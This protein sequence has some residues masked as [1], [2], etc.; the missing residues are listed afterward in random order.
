MRSWL[1]MGDGWQSDRTVVRVDFES[2]GEQVDYLEGRL[3]G[4]E[5]G[6]SNSAR[7]LGVVLMALVSFVGPG[8]A[9]AGG[10]T[11][12]DE[13][14]SLF[15]VHEVALSGGDD[16][17]NPFDKDCQVTFVPPSGQ[18]VTVDCF[19]DGDGTW[20]ARVYVRKV[21]VWNW[22]SESQDD[23]SLDGQSGNFQAETS[24]L[25]GMLK[26]HRSNPHVWMTD[27][28]TT[29]LHISDTAYR[30]FK[31]ASVSDAYQQYVDEDAALGITG[32][33]CMLLG[34]ANWD[35]Y[36]AGG[37]DGSK[38]RV[39]IAS[40]Q[41]SEDRLKWMLENHPEVYVQLILFPDG[42]MGDDTW[43]NGHS[44][45]QREKM[46]RYIIARFAAFPNMFWEVMNDTMV[47]SQQQ[48]P[49][50]W[51]AATDVGSYFR[52][53]DPFGH[54]IAFGH[55]RDYEYPFAG[56]DWSTYIIGYTA[57][58]IACDLVDWYGY[59]QYEKH[60]YNTEDYY[61]TYHPPAH[62]R[63]F[64]RRFVWSYLLSGA[65]ATY[66]GLWDDIIPYSSSGMTGL[67]DIIHIRDFFRD[68]HID[69]AWFREADEY[70]Q[71]T[72]APGPEYNDGPSRPQCA[73]NG[74]FQ[75]VIYVPNARSGE[76]TGIS[77]AYGTTE[78]E[79]RK[80]ASLD[81][82]KTPEIQV[83]LTSAG[84]E[85]FSVEWFRS[86]D[87]ATQM[88]TSIEGGEWRTLT[89]PW[90]GTD[91]VVLVTNESGN[92]PPSVTIQV[93]V[94]GDWI[95]EGQE[96]Y[97]HVLASDSDGQIADVSVVVD[98]SEDDQVERLDPYEWNLAGLA[99]GTHRIQA[100]AVDDRGTSSLSDVV[101]FH[102]GTQTVDSDAGTSSDGEVDG[103][104]GTV[105][106]DSQVDGDGG[107]TQ[108]DD[109]VQGGCSCTTDGGPNSGAWLLLFVFA[110][111]WLRRRRGVSADL[112][113]RR[114]DE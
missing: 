51:F 89:S 57:Y 12:Q 105:E 112:L 43:S 80:N 40:F 38:E 106:G 78:E 62:P 93:P 74:T 54:L 8:S 98:G 9:L 70:A 75:F 41:H 61:E 97:V 42:K 67:D 94:E 37:L 11:T 44:E 7:L 46:K 4:E 101:S 32:L 48:D 13:A 59:R 88:G 34:E 1:T 110:L 31:D 52:D 107:G 92:E 27:R 6:R 47:Q 17:G 90:E 104:G 14:A 81:G 63:Y 16:T 60:V 21:G 3:L 69:L 20:R 95:A 103:D 2:R 84:Q 26:S 19:Y 96:V 77:T 109:G 71:Q 33:R 18:P 76:L 108:G 111:P 15:G 5:S 102:V 91:V 85:T 83:N 50:N 30:L 10:F 24:S 65:S 99:V 22:V 53:H 66:A 68:H 25:P 45:A 86:T 23:A 35:L 79:S 49:D 56:D 28:G 55:R 73:R 72:N 58:D 82:S 87:G 100:R 113:A 114:R 36:W 39:N 29:F 64:Y